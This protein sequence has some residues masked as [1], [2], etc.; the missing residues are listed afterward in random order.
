MAAFP[1]QMIYQSSDNKANKYIAVEKIVS[2][3]INMLPSV[4]RSSLV[5]TAHHSILKSSFFPF[6]VYLICDEAA[7]IS[8]YIEHVIFALIPYRNY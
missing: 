1:N 2:M 4:K 7:F 6:A 5:F 8:I 3:V